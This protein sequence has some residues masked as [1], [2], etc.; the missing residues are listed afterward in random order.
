M[1]EIEAPEAVQVNIDFTPAPGRDEA[2]YG[3]KARQNKT[4]CSQLAHDFFRNGVMR[5]KEQNIRSG[6][7]KDNCLS[8]LIPPQ[9]ERLGSAAASH[10]VGAEPGAALGQ[11]GQA[12][13]Q[14][15]PLYATLRNF[16]CLFG[17]VL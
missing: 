9:A 6:S 17:T 7:A 1:M 10:C 12:R 16:Y 14:I 4:K 13:G 2:A 8:L 5:A 3:A 15:P 11:H